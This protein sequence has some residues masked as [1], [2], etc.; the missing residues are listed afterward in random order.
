MA[1]SFG[2]GFPEGSFVLIDGADGAGKSVMSQRFVAGFCSEGYDVTFLTP[3]YDAGTFIDQMR[4]LSYEVVDYL[5]T[6]RNL[7]FFHT[8]V[9]V[10]QPLYAADPEERNLFL[11][12]LEVEA[13]WDSD[14]IIIDGLD[15]LLNNDPLFREAAQTGEEKQFIQDFINFVASK[16]REGKTVII[17]VNGDAVADGFLS[18]MRKQASVYVALEM[19]KRAGSIQRQANV[20]RFQ[21]R[22]Q[23]ADDVISYEVQAGNGLMIKSQSVA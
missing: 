17:T 3:E 11:D 20:K 22:P 1:S 18:P 7:L 13:L 23:K 9:N 6:E 21:N 2:G 8:D 10:D 19:T 14:I 5:M 4:S 16:R 12:L 15:L